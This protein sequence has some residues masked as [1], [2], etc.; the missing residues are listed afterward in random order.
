MNTITQMDKLVN[1][2]KMEVNLM[3][4]DKIQR[5]NWKTS[6][7]QVGEFQSIHKDMLFVNKEYQRDAL[8]DKV[9]AI[10]RGWSW[11]ACGA[12][13]VTYRDGSIWVIDGQHRVLAAKNR[14][15][16]SYLPCMVFQLDGLKGEAQG[17]L[18]LNTGRKPVS[19]VGKQKALVTAGDEV[20]IFVQNE[21]DR[22]G[23][24]IAATTKSAG[25]IQSIAWCT[26]RAREDR[27]AFSLVLSLAAEI[28]QQDN[29]PVRERLLDGLWFLH[30]RMEGGLANKRLLQKIKE[31]GGECLINSANKASAYYGS[32]GAK[33]WGEGML[34]E[35]NKGLVHKFE[36]EQTT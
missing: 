32:G 29:I 31:K 16:I 5:Y 12:I 4:A 14:S 7:N 17:F 3:G 19:A 10:A 33:V 13:I 2:R 1:T 20:A 23:L 22:I 28:S 26:K 34:A 8:N 24:R 18:D 30:N 25:Q 6:I 36:L 11:V 21:I 35:L 9:V 27:V 15:D